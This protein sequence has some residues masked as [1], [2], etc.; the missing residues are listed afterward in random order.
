M[1]HQFDDRERQNRYGD[2]TL[3]ERSGKR[4]SERQEYRREGYIGGSTWRGEG[5]GSTRGMA[6]GPDDWTRAGP[7][8]GR[9]PRGYRRSDERIAEDVCERLTQHGQVDARDIN[10]EV[11]DGEVTLRGTVAERRMKRLAEDVAESVTG[12]EDVHN[13]LRLAPRGEQTQVTGQA[14]PCGDVQPGM[15]VTGRFG[16]LIGEIHEVRAQGF[17]VNRPMASQVYIPFEYCKQVNGHV[18]L[19]LSADEVDQN[20]PYIP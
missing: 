17:L 12:V 19:N 14:E 13:E 9:G 16:G 7:H 3:D 18:V 10:V 11:H 20:W 4:R 5:A 8:T 2:E 1:A 6:G 15:Q